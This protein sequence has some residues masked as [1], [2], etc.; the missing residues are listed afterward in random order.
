VAQAKDVDPILRVI[1]I[2]R[3]IDI[4]GRG[5]PALATALAGHLKAIAD[6]KLDLSVPWLD[7]ERRDAA[8]VRQ[9]AA[10]VIRELPPFKPCVEAA[11]AARKEL[12]SR[13]E[14]TR[15]PLAGWLL[16]DT[17]GGWQCVPVRSLDGTRR[18]I[19]FAPGD[20]KGGEW[21]PV[22]RWRDGK[23]VIDPDAR[24]GM[25]DGRLVFAEKE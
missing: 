17:D 24:K 13:I 20:E 25:L 8:E 3:L 11:A 12:A 5:N 10:Q 2:R 1:L 6:A 21:V 7:P 18:L 15:R 22:G 23:A 4:A 16:Q 19:V 9:A 14:R